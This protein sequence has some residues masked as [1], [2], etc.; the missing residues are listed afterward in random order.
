MRK[1]ALR[2][3]AAALALLSLFA[4][5]ALEFPH[6]PRLAAAGGG[7]LLGGYQLAAGDEGTFELFSASAAGGDIRRLGRYNG[8]LAG[9]AAAPDGRMLALTR[10]GSLAAYGDDAETLCHPDDRWRMMALAWWGEGPVAVNLDGGVLS[11]LRPSGEM[12]WAPASTIGPAGPVRRLELAAE[13]GRLHVLWR[14]A[15]GD[16]SRGEIR[17]MVLDGETWR[18]GESLPTG[19]ADALAAFGGDAVTV[20][21]RIPDI[22]GSRDSRVVR[23][24][25]RGGVWQ[26]APL[27]DALRRRLL[28]AHSFAA[29]PGTEA[30]WLTAGL[31]GAFLGG[32][33]GGT[34]AVA[35]GAP[36][37]S[38][39]SRA[40]GF[41]TLLAML[42]LLVLY[43]RRSR[44]MSK[45][46][47]GRPPDLLSRGAALGIDWFLSSVAATAYH[48]ASGDVRILPELL[49]RQEFQEMFWVNLAA[50][51]LFMGLCEGFFG[52]TP[53]KWLA[54]LRVRSAGGGP[55]TFFQGVLRNVLRIVDM[56]PTAGFPGLVGLVATLFGRERQ[57]IGDMVAA[58][59]VRRCASPA[60][61]RF[62][63]ASASPRR[64]ELLRALGVE[65]RVQPSNIDE[66][67]VKGD[68]PEETV[69]LLSMAKARAAMEHVRA[70]EI[71]V[72]AD[73]VVVLD[74]AVLG[75]PRDA[76]DAR[77]MLGRL[78]GRSHS[79]F[80]GVTVWD[81][82]T[83]Q[84]LTNLEET[85]VEFRHLSSGEIDAYVASGDPLDKAGGYGV[86]SGTLVKQ[87]RGSLSN[88]AGLPMEKLQ[89]MVAMLD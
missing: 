73:T 81:S 2:M 46:F 60:E 64:E 80:T 53:G 11:L 5:A 7:T 48:I 50:L 17:H 70:G 78:S 85:E 28:E 72:A 30:M 74:G 26:N 45:N 35:P 37:E 75:K 68:T 3:V 51:C 89:G 39:W 47:P 54:G 40:A 86:Q 36:E 19:E 84:G 67:G 56:F 52:A 13:G 14:E 49:A 76:A 10:D 43:C 31:D 63:L 44:V 34:V 77:E 66:D 79:V 8:H 32:T 82:A 59:V 61:R 18:E 1:H 12:S 22:P 33:T 27:P 23:Q 83:G 42:A 69:K 16:L 71:V 6:S 87:V 57:R 41:A 20:A 15:D 29:A 58:T 24:T 4:A 65:V 88:V 38:L 21:A 25:L 62:L 55:A 9:V